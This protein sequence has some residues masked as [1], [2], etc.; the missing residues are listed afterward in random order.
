MIATVDNPSNAVEWALAEMMN[1]PHILAK[2]REE[3]D[4]VVG[5]DRLVQESDMPK[6]NYV[7]ACLK[8]SFRLHPLAPFN[9]PH[10]PS[11]DTVVGGY[12]IPKG[13]YVVLSRLG[14]GRNPRVWDEP[15][16]FIPERH[17]LD[18]ETSSVTLTDHELRMLS[19]STGRRGCPGI[20]L[21]STMSTMLLARLVQGFRWSPPPGMTSIDLAE[22]SGDELALPKFVA[23]ATPRLDPDIYFPT[24]GEL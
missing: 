1:Q 15:L 23:C 7:K 6:L 8:E 16:R 21:G 3:L 17:I 18:H 12:F 14:L 11:Q 20:V 19:F 13:S 4:G 24:H 5:K 9:I 2:A 22:S 10:V